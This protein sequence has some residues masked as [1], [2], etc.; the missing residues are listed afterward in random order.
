MF[1]SMMLLFLAGA[2]VNI[3]PILPTHCEGFVKLVSLFWENANPH[4][5]YYTVH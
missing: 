4:D 1:T 2:Q 3:Q 5:P